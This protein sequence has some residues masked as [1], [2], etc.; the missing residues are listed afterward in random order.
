MSYPRQFC[1]DRQPSTRRRLRGSRSKAEQLAQLLGEASELE[2]RVW[3]GEDA[4]APELAAKRKE[5][6]T[7]RLG[8]TTPCAGVLAFRQ[9]DWVP[10]AQER[11]RSI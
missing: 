8:G 2:R 7:L 6:K 9:V 11:W 4:L 10:A 5:M 3:R 1:S